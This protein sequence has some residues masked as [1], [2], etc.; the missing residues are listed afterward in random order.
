MSKSEI[1]F[2]IFLAV[3]VII[4]GISILP[5]VFENASDTP[6]DFVVW[7]RTV[8][9]T[10]PA[11]ASSI[12]SWRNETYTTEPNDTMF[13]PFYQ[14]HLGLFIMVMIS[15]ILSMVIFIPASAKTF[16]ALIYW[17]VI[18]FLVDCFVMVYYAAHLSGFYVAALVTPDILSFHQFIGTSTVLFLS[19]MGLEFLA[20]FWAV[21]IRNDDGHVPKWDRI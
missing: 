2:L 8:E 10:T 12:W 13:L 18:V 1:F 17:N 6:S 14:A 3:I 15:F 16:T 19:A 7:I 20:I 11:I 4:K 9:N 21:T 5:A